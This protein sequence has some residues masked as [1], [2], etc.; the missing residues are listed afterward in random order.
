M[1][2]LREM[3]YIEPVSYNTLYPFQNKHQI[4]QH[5]QSVQMLCASKQSKRSV[6]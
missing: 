3:E 2:L 1:G 5:L 6:S 4:H